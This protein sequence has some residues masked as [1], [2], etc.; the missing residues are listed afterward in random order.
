MVKMAWHKL[1]NFRA[2]AQTERLGFSSSLISIFR[3]LFEI[4]IA[5]RTIRNSL[6]MWNAEKVVQADDSTEHSRWEKF[7]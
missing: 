5:K 1:K 6:K 7:V 4:T 3:D 2:W